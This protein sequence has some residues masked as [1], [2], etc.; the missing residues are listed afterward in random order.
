LSKTHIQELDDYSF[1]VL[2]EQV[3]SS[4]QFEDQTHERVADSLRKFITTTKS[5]LTIGLEGGWGAILGILAK[6]V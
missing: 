6:C 1:E 4:D 5:G 3:A 2:Q